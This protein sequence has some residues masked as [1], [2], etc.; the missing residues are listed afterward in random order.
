[1]NLNVN[2]IA[3]RPRG[4]AFRSMSIAVLAMAA[5]L[6]GLLAM[7][8]TRAMH[9]MGVTHPAASAHAA[10]TLGAD[11]MTTVAVAAVTVVAQLDN[12]LVTCLEDCTVDCDPMA[13]TCVVLLI[14]ASL[15]MLI[16][17]PSVYQRL[18][19]AGGYIVGSFRT[20]PLRIHRPSLTVLSISRT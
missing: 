4:H 14:L 6:L 17:L 8:S 5:M 15:V 20:T 12:G 7:H 18:L 13:M 19:D 9:E 1:M 16:R 3:H 2:A 10:Q 11:P